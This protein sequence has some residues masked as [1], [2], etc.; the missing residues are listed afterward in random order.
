MSA[1]SQR[2]QKVDAM[3]ERIC[4]GHDGRPMTCVEISKALGGAITPQRVSQ[5]ERKATRRIIRRLHSIPE[6]RYLFRP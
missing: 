1:R 6:F 2:I 3:L 4:A 5:I